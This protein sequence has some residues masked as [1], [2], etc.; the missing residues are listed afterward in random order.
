MRPGTRTLLT[1]A[2]LAG[3]ALAAGC[4]PQTFVKQP[5]GWKSIELREPL[6]NDY[7]EA[8]QTAVDTI[9][10][11]YDIELLDKDSGY[12]RTT[13]KHGISG[14]SMQRYRGR[15]TLKFDSVKD[16]AKAE[17]KTE[18]SWYEDSAFYEG[19]V[20]GYDSQFERDIYGALSG[21]LGRTA[22]AD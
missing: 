22:P 9:A 1:V 6:R 21:R 7:S 14:G 13:W 5:S 3:V 2:M 20:F 19:W 15:L 12:L 17:V 18:A 8:W 16:P 11:D 4:A 10:R